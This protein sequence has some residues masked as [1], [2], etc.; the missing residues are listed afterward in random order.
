MPTTRRKAKPKTDAELIIKQASLSWRETETSDP[1]TDSVE[2]T[3]FN[4]SFGVL[5][6]FYRGTITRILAPGVWRDLNVANLKILE[7]AP[8]EEV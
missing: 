1:R 8:A 4:L 2:F 6:L 5:T 3:A 7:G